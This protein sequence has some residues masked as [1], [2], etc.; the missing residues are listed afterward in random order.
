MGKLVQSSISKDVSTVQDSMVLSVYLIVL[1]ALMVLNVHIAMQV[2]D[3]AII[4]STTN[5]FLVPL[6]GHMI[7]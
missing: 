4:V 1:L 6:V 5:A 7:I 2:A 3:P